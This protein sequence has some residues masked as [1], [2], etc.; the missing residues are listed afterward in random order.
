MTKKRRPLNYYKSVVI[1]VNSSDEFE[2]LTDLLEVNNFAY[3]IDDVKMKNQSSAARDITENRLKEEELIKLKSLVLEQIQ[4]LVTIT[5]LKGTITYVNNAQK[6]ILGRDIEELI[7]KTT[8][9]YGENED[10]GETQENIVK[11]TLKDGFWRG[12]VANYDSAGNLHIMDC[13]CQVVN[14]NKGNPAVL[15]GIATDITKYKN[16]QNAIT[17]SEE[18]F[19]SI[20]ENSADVIALT[21]VNGIITYASKRTIEMFLIE[22]DKMTGRHFTDFLDNSS[23]KKAVEAFI[24]SFK[25]GTGVKN[26][27]LLM[28]KNDGSTF[29]GELSGTEFNTT[30]EKGSLVV[31]RDINDRK[32]NE[33]ALQLSLNRWNEAQKASATGNWEYDIESNQYWGS[34]EAFRILGWDE[35]FIKGNNNTIPSSTYEKIL[36]DKEKALRPLLELIKYNHP[37]DIEFEIRSVVDGQRRFMSSRAQL[38]DV[39]DGKPKKVYGTIQDVTEK[40]LNNRALIENEHR[41]K[42]IFSYFPDKLILLDSENRIVLLNH[43]IKVT[44]V[45]DSIGRPILDVIPEEFIQ[46][47]SQTISRVIKTGISESFDLETSPDT[48]IR[49]VN[50]LIAPVKIMDDVS[51]T[52]LSIRDISEQKQLQKS[53]EE[54]KIQY[55]QAQKMEA[56]GRLAGGIAHDFNNIMC[57][58]SGNISLIMGESSLENSCTEYLEEIS[59]ASERAT[60]LTKQLLAFSRKQIMDPG[61]IDFLAVVTQL[62]PMLERLLGEN[63][64]LKLSEKSTP[65]FFTGDQGQIEQILVNLVVNARDA[66]PESGGVISIYTEKFHCLNRTRVTSGFLEPGN[67]SVLS[68]LDN[69]TGIESEISEHIFE[70]FFTTKEVGKGSGLGLSTVLGITEQNSGYIDLISEVGKGSE[71]RI[72][73]PSTENAKSQQKL[74]TTTTRAD[75]SG[76]ETIL[77]VED[78]PMVRKLSEKILR[79][80]GYNVISAASGIDALDTIK[81]NNYEIQVLLTDVI[82]PHMNGRELAEKI[83]EIFPELRVLYTSGYTRDVIA[84]HGI[85]E[86]DINFISKPYSIRELGEKIRSLLDNT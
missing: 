28:K 54:L 81:N 43:R 61:R 23:K 24:S 47:L 34:D 52:L 53:N 16:F 36:V 84:K 71:F 29:Y 59:K 19:R 15:S 12:E 80:Q 63:M 67:Y 25:T 50:I 32:E 30:G 68:V 38:E 40:Y 74:S 27:E 37:F 6:L 72:F 78:D 39:S 79:K 26:L 1:S 51:G 4:D 17:A 60:Q 8:S 83:L 64:V 65:S 22:P 45:E 44:T 2:A 85:L 13:R 69:G 76:T 42:S 62:K 33:K 20:T 48:N 77:V 18:K 35:Q 41:L 55:F 7:G 75:S 31:I 11:K 56:I 14:D 9:I 86:S 49:F 70:P 82:M 73:F 21:D 46:P 3:S 58:I 66:L 5:D 10:F 57:A